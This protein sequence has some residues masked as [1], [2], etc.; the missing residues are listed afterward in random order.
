[1]DYSTSEYDDFMDHPTWLHSVGTYVVTLVDLTN[2][3]GRVLHP[4]GAVGVLVRQGLN[5]PD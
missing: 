3:I 4:R 1:M 2:D 5:T